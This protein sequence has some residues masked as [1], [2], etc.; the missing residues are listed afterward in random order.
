M[1]CK[2]TFIGVLLAPLIPSLIF[3]GFAGF[4]SSFIFSYLFA[5][6]FGIPV[7]SVLKIKKKESHSLYA[8][9]GFFCG[10]A[11]VLVP[12][13]GYIDLSALLASLIFG[14]TGLITALCFSFIQ[15]KCPM[16]AG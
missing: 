15:G 2:R 7:I 6:I 5:W 3:A 14:V 12:S 9:L 16:S 4:T 11:Y 10:I 8:S 13:L 1:K